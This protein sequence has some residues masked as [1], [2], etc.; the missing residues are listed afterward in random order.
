MAERIVK[1]RQGSQ[2]VNRIRLQIYEPAEDVR[3]WVHSYWTAETDNTE[4]AALFRVAN[5]C[6]TG[7]IFILDGVQTFRVRE[8]FF[9]FGAGAVRT[10]PSRYVCEHGFLG[11]VR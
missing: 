2:D 7:W 8:Q 6:G 5:N 4:G 10:G 3:G 1:S 11:P 9:S